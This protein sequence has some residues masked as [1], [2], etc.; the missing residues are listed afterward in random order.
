VLVLGKQADFLRDF[1]GDAIHPSTLKVLHEFGLLE[2]L[3]T[4]PHQEVPRINT[5][6]GDLALAVADFPH[7]RTQCRGVAFMP[8]W[9]FLNFLGNRAARYPTFRLRMQVEVTEGIRVG[10]L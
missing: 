2:D 9:D 6:F 8:Q 4:L 3:L 7:L 10:S 1:R 5:Q